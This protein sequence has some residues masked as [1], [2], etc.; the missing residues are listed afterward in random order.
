[1]T[2]S[3]TEVEEHK[4]SVGSCPWVLHVS[5]SCF[6]GFSLVI[7]PRGRLG[8]LRGEFQSACEDNE[9]GILG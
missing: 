1:M 4:G 7:D 8:G 6:P 2:S 3:D 5:F 9:G